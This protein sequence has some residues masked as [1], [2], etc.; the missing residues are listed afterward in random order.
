MVEFFELLRDAKQSHSG[1]REIKAA[2]KSDK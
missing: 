1:D 2:E